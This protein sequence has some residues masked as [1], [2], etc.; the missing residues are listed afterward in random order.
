VLIGAGL[1]LATKAGADIPAPLLALIPLLLTALVGGPPL[2]RRLR[3]AASPP[4]LPA[5]E[6]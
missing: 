6:R 2:V 1:G 3:G 4:P 5:P